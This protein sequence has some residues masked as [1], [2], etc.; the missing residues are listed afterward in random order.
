[1]DTLCIFLKASD[2]A[3]HYLRKIKC[4]LFLSIC[5]I[6]FTFVFIKR[7][8]MKTILLSNRLKTPSGILFY[9]SILYG[10]CANFY[11][12]TFLPELLVSVPNNLG[13]GSAEILKQTDSF[14]IKNN[15]MDELLIV[16]IVASGLVHSFSK[17]RQE[18][19]LVNS[20]RLAAM[21]WAIVANF[22]LIILGTLLIYGIAYFEFMSFSLF[23]LLV[24]YNLKFRILYRQHL[25]Q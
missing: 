10:V 15:F 5:K 22:C 17:E 20:L 1:M 8:I 4:K 6:Y 24:I 9:A 3:C 2:L 16:L 11:P 25:K 23:S 14:W 12:E 13:F 19:E 7:I 18:D 21:Q